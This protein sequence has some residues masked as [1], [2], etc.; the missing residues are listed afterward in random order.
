MTTE[1][2]GIRVLRCRSGAIEWGI[3]VEILREIAPGG[4]VA[5]VPGT[6]A[7]VQGIVNIRG[8]VMT[9][10]DSRVFL[11]QPPGEGPGTL[12]VVEVGGRRLALS[13]DEVEDLLTVAIESLEPTTPLPDQPVG[14]VIALVREERPFLLLDIEA[15]VAPLFGAAPRQT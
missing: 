13:V 7:A 10:L 11:G 6:P 4:A 14:G 2:S 12:V 5:P 9:A 15:L 8:G 1:V 3:G